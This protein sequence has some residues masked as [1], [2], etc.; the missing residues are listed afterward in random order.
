MASS[1]FESNL[2]QRCGIRHGFFSKEMGNADPENAVPLNVALG[3][4]QE[5]SV[6][7]KNR[8]CI[9]QVMGVPLE[10]F[11]FTQ[12]QHTATVKV[13]ERVEDAPSPDEAFDA[14]V[15]A[16]PNVLLAVYTADC[17]PVLLSDPDKNV[18]GVAHC[19][20]RGLQQKILEPTLE[21]MRVLGAVHVLAALGP[22]I[23]AQ[24][25]SV[26]KDFL[27]HFPED[28]DC[29]ATL[30]GKLCFDLPKLAKKQLNRLGVFEID[31]VEVD[32]Y[33]QRDLFFSFRR[34]LEQDVPL[35]GAQASVIVTA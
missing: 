33:L 18:V 29:A 19:G 34:S 8:A 21:A 25:Y 11:F 27:D 14:L 4:S 12:Q 6:V 22:C 28:L 20:W 32:T 15:T 9:A 35:A 17:V 30:N 13:V 26:S 1:F 16:L 23:H 3:R 2:F 31:D 5:D 7:L 10:R 24:H